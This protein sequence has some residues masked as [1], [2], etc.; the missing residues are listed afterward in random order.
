MKGDPIKQ[1]RLR[2][3]TGV[4]ESQVQWMAK[5]F[6]GWLLPVYG[7]Q[8]VVLLLKRHLKVTALHI[9]ADD[10]RLLRIEQ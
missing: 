7:Y 3:P 10:G 8:M 6:F 5:E 9:T 1:F 4:R 2:G